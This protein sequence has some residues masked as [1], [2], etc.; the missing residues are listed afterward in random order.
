MAKK[1]ASK[2]KIPSSKIPTSK[3]PVASAPKK[4]DLKAPT[5]K[6]QEAKAKD[7]KS[8]DIEL[9]VKIYA[10][11]AEI[12]SALTDKDELEEWWSEGVTLEPKVGGKFREAWE[13]DRGTSQ[14]ATGKVLAVKA[15]NEIRFTWREKDWPQEASTECLIQIED[16]KSHRVLSVV[17]TGWNKLPEGKRAKLIND[18]KVGWGYHLQELKSYLDDGPK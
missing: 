4:K 6:P 10:T 12:W 18:F 7:K 5:V 9:S 14:L 1:K 13:D 16:Q 17:H 15:K 3:I 2:S 8:S 11:S